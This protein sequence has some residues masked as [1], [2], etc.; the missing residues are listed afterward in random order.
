MHTGVFGGAGRLA[1]ESWVTQGGI[2]GQGGSSPSSV[3][4]PH[5]SELSGSVA[6]GLRKPNVPNPNANILTY[7]E[8]QFTEE[9]SSSCLL[10]MAFFPC[11]LFY[12]G[13]R[14]TIRGPAYSEL[15]SEGPPIANYNQRARL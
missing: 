11:G 5:L 1:E 12:A 7:I 15:Q 13:E 9:T 6:R 8:I 14:I 2:K 4:E 3:Q 10:S